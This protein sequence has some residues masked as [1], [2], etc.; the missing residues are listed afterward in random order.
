MVVVGTLG[1]GLSFYQVTKYKPQLIEHISMNSHL[2]TPK[3]MYQSFQWNNISMYIATLLQAV[4][5]LVAEFDKGES[6]C[7]VTYFE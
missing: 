1:M 2:G 4:N 6:P 3:L 5:G 7:W